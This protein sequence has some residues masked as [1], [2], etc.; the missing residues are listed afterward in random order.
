MEERMKK[1]FARLALVAFFSGIM[2][3]GLVVGGATSEIKAGP[4]DGVTG[5]W[6]TVSDKEGEKGKIKSTVCIWAHNQKLYG[7]IKVLNPPDPNKEC[8][9][10]AKIKDKKTGAMVFPK[11]EGLLIIWGLKKGDDAWE[12][13]SILDPESGKVYGCK[14][15]TEGGKLQVRGYMG[16]SALGRSQTWIK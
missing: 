9:K 3:V 13:G 1:I 15:W 5:C 10:C 11:T 4:T 8:T 12:D 16:I 2:A 14:I 7:K 6:R